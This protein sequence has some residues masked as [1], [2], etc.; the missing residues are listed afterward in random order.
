MTNLEFSREFDIL[1]NNITSNQAPSL[2]S[3][4]KSVFLTEGEEQYQQELIDGI[5]CEHRKHTPEEIRFIEQYCDSHGLLKS[6]GS[7]RHTEKHM[8]GYSS[9]NQNEIDISLVED[10]INEIQPISNGSI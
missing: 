8:M 2:N 6:G 7:D 1:Y 9:N 5:E 10:W 3:Y 4:E